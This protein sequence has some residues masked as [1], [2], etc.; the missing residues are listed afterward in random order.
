M[1]LASRLTDQAY[2]MNSDDRLIMHCAAVLSSNFT[3]HLLL[4][5]EKIVKEFGLLPGLLKPLMTETINKAF[6]AG[7]LQ[8]QTGPARRGNLKIIDKHMELLKPWPEIQKIYKVLSES[9]IRQYR[10]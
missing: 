7:P 8:A 6:D 4:L 2:R 9:I 3:N 1:K 10:V 5:T